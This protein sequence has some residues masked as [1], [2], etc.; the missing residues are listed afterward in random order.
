M[1][2][3]TF[4]PCKPDGSSET[5]VC[6]EL[7]GDGEAYIHAVHVLDQH[8]SAVHVTVWAGERQVASRGRMDSELRDVSTQPQTT[9]A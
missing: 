6:F 2:L 4:Y 8:P 9:Q 3:Y 5:F 1:A 7:L